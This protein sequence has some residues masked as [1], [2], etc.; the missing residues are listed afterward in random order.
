MTG[1]AISENGDIKRADA[2]NQSAV[3]TNLIC[4]T[5]YAPGTCVRLRL[6]GSV[7]YLLYVRQY[8]IEALMLSQIERYV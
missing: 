8:L 1:H 4:F 3:A 6:V 7:T 5:S 2:P